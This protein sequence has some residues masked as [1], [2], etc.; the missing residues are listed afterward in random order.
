[1]TQVTRE[2][3]GLPSA[4]AYTILY[5]PLCDSVEKESEISRQLFKVDTNIDYTA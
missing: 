3:P 2:I 4:T 1:M 5:L